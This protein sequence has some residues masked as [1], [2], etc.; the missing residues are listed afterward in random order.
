MILIEAHSLL[1]K[2]VLKEGVS[3]LESQYIDYV[4][5][6]T[7][8]LAVYNNRPRYDKYYYENI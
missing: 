4:I 6:G 3:I 8:A 2:K 5:G 1:M 7:N